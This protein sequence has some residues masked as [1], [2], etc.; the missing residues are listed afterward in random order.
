MEQ[1]KD[2]ATIYMIRNLLGTFF[3]AFFSFV[4]SFSMYYQCSFVEIFQRIFFYDLYTTLYLLLLWMF[5]Y[6]VFELSKILYDEYSKQVTFIPCFI[7]IGVGICVFF[8]PI[9]DL[10]QYNLCFICVLI[11]LRIVKQIWKYDLMKKRPKKG[12]E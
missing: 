12:L 11:I 7:F 3:V 1:S 4:I 8:I 2:K 6:L 10:F 5:D 9:L